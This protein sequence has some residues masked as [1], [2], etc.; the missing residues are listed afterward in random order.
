MKV[1]TQEEH[2]QKLFCTVYTRLC[3]ICNIFFLSTLLLALSSQRLPLQGC[4]SPLQNQ[5]VGDGPGCVWCHVFTVFTSPFSFSHLDT[6]SSPAKGLGAH[7]GGDKVV[8]AHCPWPAQEVCQA[9]GHTGGCVA[10]PLLCCYTAFQEEK[11][12]LVPT[13]WN[14]TCFH[15]FTHWNIT[16]SAGLKAGWLCSRHFALSVHGLQLLKEASF[17]FPQCQAHFIKAAGLKTKSRPD[18][19]PHLGYCL[20][21]ARH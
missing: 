2:L 9:V 19:Q 3:S 4:Y 7:I 13:A 20:P 16:N 14:V 17:W 8:L 15:V 5:D 11:E 21:P 6:S 12:E 18:F 1:V 10:G